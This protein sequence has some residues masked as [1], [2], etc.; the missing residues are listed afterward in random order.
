MESNLVRLA[1]VS[2]RFQKNDG[3]GRVNYEVVK[4]ALECGLQVTVLAI[5][6]AR[7]LANHPLCR[8][9]KIGTERAPT[10]LVRNLIFAFE[11][12]RWLKRH[13]SEFDILQ[14]NGFVTWQRA[15]VVAAHFIHS[16]W[17]KNRW[18]PFRS[19][20]PYELYQRLYTAL[21]SRWEKVAF[22]GARRVIAVSR[23]LVPELRAMGVREECIRVV[24]N[25][26]DTDQFSPGLSDRSHFGLPL[27]SPMALFIGDIRTPRKNLDTVL[28][29]LTTVPELELVVAG[30][31]HG[32]PYPDMARE[33]GVADRVHFLGKVTEV[34][35]LMRSVDVFVFPSHYEAHPLVL[36]EAMASGLPSVVSNTFGAE[37]FLGAGGLVLNN[38]DDAGALSAELQR[39]LVDRAEMRRMGSVARGQAERMQWFQM[40]ARYLDIYRELAAEMSTDLIGRSSGG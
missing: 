11:S 23:T 17:A 9:V 7:E 26:V 14:A 13:A 8:F 21:N 28:R 35:L 12:A 24:M 1:F 16:A 29:A 38:P 36:L 34:P 30:S 40:A 27:E 19:L 25:G 39:L 32:S 37:E 22:A 33:L 2:H 3:Q 10:E 18:Y 4:A 31:T 5:D 20:Q 6:C 15:D